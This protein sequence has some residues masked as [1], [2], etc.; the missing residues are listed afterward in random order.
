MDGRRSTAP[1]RPHH[2]ASHPPRPY[3]LLSPRSLTPPLSV[4]LRSGVL[5]TFCAPVF[6][7]PA[8]SAGLFFQSDLLEKDVE[9]HTPS[10]ERLG[11][12]TATPLRTSGLVLRVSRI[13]QFDKQYSLNEFKWKV[14]FLFFFELYPGITEDRETPEPSRTWS[15][16]HSSL[17]A[18]QR[19]PQFWTQRDFGP[20]DSEG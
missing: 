18:G 19:G 20:G 3:L 4:L 12:E 6:F 9:G 14:S 2:S 13:R 5:Q 7:T 1:L 11:R 17:G 15:Q 8:S 10:C 16:T